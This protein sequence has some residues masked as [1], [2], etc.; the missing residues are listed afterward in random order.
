VAVGARD[1]LVDVDDCLDPVGAGRNVAETAR[2]A[3]RC[4]V[5]DGDVS[6]SDL[7]EVN[8]GH[9]RAG[10]RNLIARLGFLVLRDDH[11][12]SSGDRPG[13]GTGCNGDFEA[14]GLGP[15]NSRASTEH[16][17]GDENCTN[18]PD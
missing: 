18:C 12:Q 5:D 13:P 9:R 15:E 3:E 2:I 7:L 17:A 10:R 8:G 16:N 4:A 11:D 1:T 14:R 6:G